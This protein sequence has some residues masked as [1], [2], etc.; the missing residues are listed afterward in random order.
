MVRSRDTTMKTSELLKDILYY[1][2]MIFILF[3][4]LSCEYR[5]RYPCQ[6]PENWNKIE[7]NNE[8]C[9]VEGECT[10]QVLNK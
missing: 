7:C 1:A 8:A 4:L 3:C 2:L 5:Y 9:K 6:D 10:Y